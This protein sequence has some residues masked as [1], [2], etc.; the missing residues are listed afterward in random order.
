MKK[1]LVQV[2]IIA[3]KKIS[4]AN[5]AKHPLSRIIL[6]IF[7]A[8]LILLLF[9]LNRCDRNQQLDLPGSNK[10]SEKREKKNQLFKPEI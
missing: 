1:H 5:I 6:G 8:G 3:M 2:I 10:T 9:L 7:S 4:F